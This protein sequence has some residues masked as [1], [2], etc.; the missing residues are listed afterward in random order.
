MSVLVLAAALASLNGAWSVDLR[1]TSTAPAY[2]QPMELTVAADGAVTGRFYGA[3]IDAGRASDSNGRTCFAFTT[4][5][6]T[7]PYHHAGCLKGE[8]VEGQSWSTGRN[9][10]LNWRAERTP[11]R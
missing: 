2:S 11:G 10:L 3:P 6:G 1:T 9:F 7:G 8:V 5:D 4:K